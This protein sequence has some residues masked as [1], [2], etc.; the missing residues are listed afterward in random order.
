MCK[1]DCNL[2]A[3]FLSIIG[4]AICLSFAMDVPALG[5][6]LRC[7]PEKQRSFAVSLQWII[8][9]V[10]SINGPIVFGAVIDEACLFWKESCDDE[11]GACYY[12]DNKKM[13]NYLLAVSIVCKIVSITLFV[14]S[15][16]LYKP[17][18]NEKHVSEITADI[19]PVANSGDDNP[20]F[21]GPDLASDKGQKNGCTTTF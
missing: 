5:A 15:L 17:P 10:G 21:N 3:V 12:Y 2:L 7:V 6:S 14:L 16:V 13:S 4:V 18:P 19:H 11:T 20:S 1:A 9:R 8:I